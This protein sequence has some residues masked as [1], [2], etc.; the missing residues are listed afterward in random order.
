M[1]EN[2]SG[3]FFLNTVYTQRVTQLPAEQALHDN[4]AISVNSGTYFCLLSGPGYKIND[5]RSYHTANVLRSPA[6]TVAFVATGGSKVGDC[7][8]QTFTV[9]S[10]VAS[11]H[12]RKL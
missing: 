2:V 6:D 4:I 12:Q 1:K 3:C 8:T 10:C 5:K 7:S 11:E 9:S